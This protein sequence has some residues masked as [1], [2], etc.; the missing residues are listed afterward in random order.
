[1]ALTSQ[2]KLIGAKI[3]AKRF[4]KFLFK[5]INLHIKRGQRF[6]SLSLFFYSFINASIELLIDADTITAI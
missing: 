6:I 2:V 1:M 5:N 4:Y 3:K